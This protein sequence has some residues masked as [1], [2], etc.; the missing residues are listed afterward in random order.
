MKIAINQIILQVAFCQNSNALKFSSAASDES[1]VSFLYINE[2]YSKKACFLQTGRSVS[3][4]QKCASN[5]LAFRENH[6]KLKNT[7][8]IQM[9]SCGII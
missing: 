6:V 4:L 9:F 8:C 2:L 1:F 3:F 7:G 5:V